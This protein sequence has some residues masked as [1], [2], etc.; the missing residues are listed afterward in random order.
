MFKLKIF[1]FTAKIIEQV[2]GLL[3]GFPYHHLV[4]SL[5]EASASQYGSEIMLWSM[6]SHDHS[7]GKAKGD[8]AWSSNVPSQTSTF[9]VY[10]G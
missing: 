9:S 6:M 3:S 8:P 1:N 2:N 4:S 10:I 7:I 5:H